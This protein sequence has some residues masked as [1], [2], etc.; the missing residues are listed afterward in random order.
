MILYFVKKLLQRSYTFLFLTFFSLLIGAFLF[1]S[2]VSL[3]TSVKSFLIDEGKVLI[4]GDMVL[5]SAFPIATS[6]DVFIALKNK[7]H[8]IREEEQVQAV[9]R[10]P[11][12]TATSPANVRIVDGTFP[13]YGSVTVKNG[14]QFRLTDG[15]VY[16]EEDF[17]TRLGVSV[18]D[19]VI[20]GDTILTVLG[21]ILKEPDTVALGV[22]FTPKVILLQDSFKETGL[23]LSQSRTSYRVY[24]KEN[25]VLPL[26]KN[27]IATMEAYAKENKLRFDDAT[28]GPNRLVR[29]LSSVSTFIGVVL[30]I[31]LFLVTVNIIA[32]LV[33]V[34]ARFKKTIALLKTFG[35]TSMQI[36]SIYI[37]ILGCIG[38]LAGFLG[39]ML[40]VYTV[41]SFIP[42]LSSFANAAIK[43]VSEIVIGV[44]GGLF[45]VIF[46]LC[47]SIPFLVSLREVLP[48]ELLSGVSVVKKKISIRRGVFFIPIPLLLTTLLYLISND[49]ILVLYSVGGLVILFGFFSLLSYGAIETTYRFRS[50][51][52]FII[53]SIVSFLKWRGFQTFITTASI[54]TALSGVFII[55][56]VQQN[57]ALNLN[58]NI[59]KTAP[60]LY[61]VD[62]K[63]D[64]IKQVRTIVGESFKEYPIIRGRLLSVNERDM[65]QSD[66][67]GI[68]REFNM[69][70][71]DTLIT[72]ERVLEGAFG[73]TSGG[74]NTVSFDK[75]FGDELGGVALGDIV[76]VFIQGITVT[77]RVTSIREVDST[78]GIPFFYLVYPP[79]VLS[80][81]P[82]TYFGTAN[83]VPP[84]S[85][86]LKSR[87]SVEYPNVIPIETKR[88][89][90]TVSAII[91]SVTLA[92]TLMSI[93]SII[94]GLTLI[95]VM[96]WQSLY[97]RKG[98]VLILRAFGLTKK[99]ITLL[100]ILEAGLLILVSGV[101][102]YLVAHLIAYLLNIFV[103]SFD[104]F[105]FS[106]Q[107][108][109]MILGSMVFVIVFAYV[110]STR[111]VN[112]S[113]KKLLAEK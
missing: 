26:T 107:P 87:L 17:L 25:S 81:F 53:S 61:L 69:T 19:E 101:I 28:D 21:V 79:S 76:K 47:S 16:A 68:T 41:N 38:G 5:R 1:G 8:L 106:I 20:L 4:G 109:Y 82:A 46:I 51:L 88:I 55:S 50:T 39:A 63:K 42:K 22:S 65:T 23:D 34:L 59:S 18:G 99:R 58:Q 73:D 43:P 13:L 93:P 62:I 84:E 92:V 60:A 80:N 45:G 105:T 112:D 89:L 52:P 85:E 33:Y 108:L 66:D 91:N 104:L 27:E 96:V 102:A 37:S 2:I 67:P 29:G 78:S 49:I 86:I 97:E 70:Y 98:D 36:Q 7:G 72:G 11:Y 32:N 110:L 111:I 90:E 6:S 40:G 30:T 15:G 100:F 57:I 83:V 10:V 12:G 31:A 94:L 35:A 14:S 24:V 3:T 103:F 95:L 64:Q 44:S 77:A 113:L 9:F 54:M 56:A 74:G 75:G 71:R 48:K